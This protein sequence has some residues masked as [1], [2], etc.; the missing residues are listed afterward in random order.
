MIT[1]K[2]AFTSLA[3]LGVITLFS[4]IST[5][6]VPCETLV[7]LS[8]PNTTITSAESVAAG[9]YMPP[10]GNENAAFRDMP[11]FCRVTATLR[12]SSD[13]DIKMEVW[14]PVQ[15]WNGYF[16]GRGSGGMGGSIPL[17]A[18]A[19][20][21]KSGFATAGTDTGHTGDSSYALNHPEKVIDFAYRAAH[22]MNVKAKA[23]IAA[24]YGQGP[25]LSFIDGCGTGAYTAQNAIQRYPADYDAVAITGQSH[26]SRH[27][28]WQLWGWHAV[29]K[30]ESSFIPS[31][32]FDVLHN[33]VLNACDALD[34]VRDR[35]IEDPRQCRFDPGVLQCRGADGASC[36]TRPQVEA[37]RKIYAGPS[38]PRTGEGTLLSSHAR[39]RTHLSSS[40]RSGTLRVRT[41][42]GEEFRI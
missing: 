37:M 24:Y 17:P 13:S 42:M 8:L 22:E 23:I 35:E 9:A 34:G 27:R 36:L 26:M 14:M 30:D 11:A 25:K 15:G 10:A 41:G 18:M 31:E 40:N 5:A 7:S 19:A 33:A 32:K 21:L 29:H 28:V 6:A 12:P 2:S 16:Q 38:N 4:P 20:T 39:K 3:V 1:R